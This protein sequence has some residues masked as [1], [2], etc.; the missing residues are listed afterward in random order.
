MKRTFI[1]LS[2]LVTTGAL[3]M[4]Q[5]PALM[6]AVQNGDLEAVQQLSRDTRTLNTRDAYGR[7]PLMLAARM[8]HIEM[9]KTLIEA[10]VDIDAKDKYGFTA[11]EL[12]ESILRR[13]PFSSPEYLQERAEEMRQEGLSEDSIRKRIQVIA[14]SAV[15]GPTKTEEDI[16]KLNEVLHYLRQIKES[17]SGMP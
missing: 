9:A 13:I 17:R 12:L 11:I 2:I 1:I 5:K 8:G 3:A 14:D 15:P 6:E 10:G 4:Q 16:R 7:T